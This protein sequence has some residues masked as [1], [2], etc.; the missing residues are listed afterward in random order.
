MSTGEMTIN[1]KI[2]EGGKISSL[3]NQ[4]VRVINLPIQGQEGQNAFQDF[5]GLLG[6]NVFSEMLSRNAC[7]Y[8]GTP[9]RAFLKNYC[10]DMASHDE[11]L[12]SHMESFV[13][14]HCPVESS[15]QVKRVAREF[16][17][18]AA[19]GELA[20]IFGVLPYKKGESA[21]AATKFRFLLE[22]G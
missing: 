3:A 16:A 18:I 5:H 21:Q 4:E 12:K 15:G 17:L 2:E 22:T 14:E 19:V 7:Q 10:P 8:Y 11:V 9:L 1:E 20:A 6:G 13:A